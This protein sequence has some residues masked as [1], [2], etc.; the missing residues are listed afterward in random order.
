MLRCRLTTVQY[1]TASTEAVDGGY[2]LSSD[3]KTNTD[4]QRKNAIL[5]LGILNLGNPHEL[6]IR[7]RTDEHGTRNEDC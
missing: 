2:A 1:P 4:S 6:S 5:Y 3:A 7:K